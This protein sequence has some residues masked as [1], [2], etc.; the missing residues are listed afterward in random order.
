MNKES[1]GSRRE[2]SAPSLV[3]A[4]QHLDNLQK[5][6]CDMYIINVE[7]SDERDG[8]IHVTLYSWENQETRELFPC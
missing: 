2:V 7:A 8:Y 6:F 1:K 4:L 3:D 5:S